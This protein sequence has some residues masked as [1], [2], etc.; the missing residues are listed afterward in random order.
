MKRSEQLVD[1]AIKVAELKTR[2]EI[3][4]QWGLMDLLGMAYA[5][6]ILDVRVAMGL[7]LEGEQAEVRSG[8]KEG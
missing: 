5:E 7:E 1:L 6:A 2:A 3:L 4:E 8:E